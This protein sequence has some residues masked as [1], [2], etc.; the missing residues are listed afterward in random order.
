METQA[1]T[2]RD[3]VRSS[4][5]TAARTAFLEAVA[6]VRAAE[7]RAGGSEAESVDAI[8]SAEGNETTTEPAT[9]DTQA[10]TAVDPV[11]GEAKEA[12]LGQ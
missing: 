2:A 11:K 9:V 3:S 6:L 10:A 12:G 5:T 7:V 4:M 8:P 1:A